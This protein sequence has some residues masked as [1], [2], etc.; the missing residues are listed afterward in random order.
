[1]RSSASAWPLAAAGETTKAT[2]PP[3]PNCKPTSLSA[4]RRASA[5]WRNRTKPI[6]ETIRPCTRGLFHCVQGLRRHFTLRRIHAKIP[7]YEQLGFNPCATL[8]GWLRP[9]RPVIFDN[10]FSSRHS[11]PH[12]FSPPSCGMRAP[13][14]PSPCRPMPR[15]GSS[16]TSPAE[17]WPPKKDSP[18]RRRP[19]ETQAA[20]ADRPREEA[21]ARRKRKACMPRRGRSAGGRMQ[22]TTGTGRA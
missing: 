3:C 9:C 2:R 13:G 6:P 1:M 5:T 21:I 16:R 18:R 4:Q 20:V 22:A 7:P 11:P 12:A 14:P 15:R 17:K 19:A 8:N 10:A